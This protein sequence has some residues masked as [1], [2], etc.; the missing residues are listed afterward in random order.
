M[1]IDEVVKYCGDARISYINDRIEDILLDIGIEECS[2]VNNNLVDDLYFGLYSCIDENNF[3]IDGVC[4][5]KKNSLYSHDDIN[6]LGLKEFIEKHQDIKNSI[7]N[8]CSLTKEEQFIKVFDLLN[9]NEEE[10]R[11]VSDYFNFD[12]VDYSSK[13]IRAEEI[14]QPPFGRCDAHAILDLEKDYTLEVSTVGTDSGMIELKFSDSN[15]ECSFKISYS[16]LD[17]SFFVNEVSE[18]YSLNNLEGTKLFAGHIDY[19]IEILD[20]I[21]DNLE[22]NL[23]VVK[24]VHDEIRDIFSEELV[25]KSI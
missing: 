23:R 22:D 21:H 17:D 13:S 24:E 10:I 3:T 19:I 11:D 4:H 15:T 8:N 20:D 16:S 9:K 2:E 5:V 14:N 18:G 7:V 6:V 12:Y 25:T 1:R